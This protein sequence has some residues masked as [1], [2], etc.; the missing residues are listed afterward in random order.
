MWKQIFSSPEKVAKI[1]FDIFAVAS[2]AALPG[3]S[4]VL[5]TIWDIESEMFASE[6]E[7][8]QAVQNYV[9]QLKTNEENNTERAGALKKGSESTLATID[10]A[11]QRSKVYVK[12]FVIGEDT[13]TI[14]PNKDAVKLAITLGRAADKPRRTVDIGYDTE[15]STDLSFITLELSEE[16]DNALSDFSNR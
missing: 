14:P 16:S 4:A 6:N 15:K 12:D 2:N 7:K 5:E 13:V 1:P 3:A 10:L 9:N 8:Q 11:V